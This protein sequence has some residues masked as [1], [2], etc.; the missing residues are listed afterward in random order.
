MEI[1]RVTQAALRM[2]STVDA[3][4]EDR[5]LEDVVPRPVQPKAKAHKVKVNQERLV[6]SAS[7]GPGSR[8]ARPSSGERL[9]PHWAAFYKT[10]DRAISGCGRKVKRW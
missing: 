6:E 2:R 5:V 4:L 1:T 3:T 8:N 9:L 7:F 10:E